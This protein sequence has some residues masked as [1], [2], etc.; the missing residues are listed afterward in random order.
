MEEFESL[1]K[2]NED[3]LDRY[4]DE[5]VK[6]S[7]QIPNL[8]EQICDKRGDPCDNLCGG[9]GCKHCGGLSC[10]NG[11]VTKAE[12]ALAYAEDTEKEI[13]KKEEVAEDLIRS[14]SQAKTNASEAYKKSEKAFIEADN[15]LNETKEL[16]S[17]GND[18]IANLTNVLNNNTASPDEIRNIAEQTSALNLELD[19]EEIKALA[20][21]IDETVSQLENVEAIIYNT[22]HDL[23]RVEQLKN[24]A[25]ESRKRAENVLESAQKVVQALNEADLAQKKAKEAISAANED[26]SLA[27]SDLEQID[28][29][30]GDAQRKA[31]ETSNKVNDLSSKLNELQKNFL[32][33]DYD[34]K[35]IKQQADQVR[36]AAHNAH[37][38]ATKLR[39][40]YRK[41]NDSLTAKAIT[42]ESA[43]ERAQQLLQRA[44]KI[45]V[46][47]SSKL[48]ELQGMV[49]IYKTN[50]KELNDLE[51]RVEYLNSQMNDYLSK[52]QS[53]S[54]RYRQCTS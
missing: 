52:I 2:T 43:R 35:E 12:K 23:E 50:D 31:S 21:K 9:A 37:E 36:D 30:T 26:I 29:E 40:N 51:K 19:P 25:N 47:T 15:Y 17:Q 38:D 22:R 32:K 20:N 34:A 1:Q 44:S 28:S 27:K 24:Q 10:E 6:L 48:K 42:S 3:A 13:K 33:N 5:I 18:L 45:T 54:V 16:I 11:A 7:A 39:D 46:E 41:A 4:H 49:D 14:L 53:D 8:N